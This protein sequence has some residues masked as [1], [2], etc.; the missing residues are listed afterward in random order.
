MEG[1]LM[2]TLYFKSNGKKIR[3]FFGK[4]YRQNYKLKFIIHIM[5]KNTL[6][7]MKQ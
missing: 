4:V 3:Y 2:Y 5:K 1:T 6:I 7:L